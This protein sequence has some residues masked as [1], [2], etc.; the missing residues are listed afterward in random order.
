MK[1]D[2]A[3][4]GE[5]ERGSGREI[6]REIGGLTGIFRLIQRKPGRKPPG[7]FRETAGCGT[8]AY[9]SGEAFFGG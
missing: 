8:K 2:R 6:W 1:R 5:R 4:K 3:G 7:F 9:R